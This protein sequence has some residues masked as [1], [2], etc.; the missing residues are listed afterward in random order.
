VEVQPFQSNAFGT[1]GAD[2]YAIIEE[3]FPNP[4]QHYKQTLE[5][6]KSGDWAKQFEACNSLKR[7]AMFHKPL[8]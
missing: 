3:P 1:S 2:M 5:K 4:E 6:L 7:I 8:L